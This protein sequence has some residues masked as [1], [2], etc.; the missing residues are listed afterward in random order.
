MWPRRQL[1]TEFSL[2]S[3]D[4]SWRMISLTLLF[5][6]NRFCNLLFSFSRWSTFNLKPSTW[7]SQPSFCSL[8]WFSRILPQ[9]VK[10]CQT[11]SKVNKFVKQAQNC[12]HRHKV[13]GLLQS[14]V[15]IDLV[16]FWRPSKAASKS[17][18]SQIF[19]ESSGVSLQRNNVWD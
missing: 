8:W 10:P 9:K 14:S 3:L 13:R 16:A 7:V 4:S 2:L 6:W 18:T 15:N 19:S 12:L 11:G 1:R 17:S 5:S